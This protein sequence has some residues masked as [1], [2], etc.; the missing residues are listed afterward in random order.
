MK[1]GVPQIAI[2]DN[3]GVISYNALVTKQDKEEQPSSPYI[4]ADEGIPEEETEKRRDQRLSV[5]EIVV[6]GLFV[7]GVL[8]AV[9]TT[10]YGLKL[11][12][13]RKDLPPA[14]GTA[15][16][17]APE[18]AKTIETEWQGPT[19]MIRFRLFLTPAIAEIRYTLEGPSEIPIRF[20]AL[21]VASK[22]GY[23]EIL[24][25]DSP[26]E[27]LRPKDTAERQYTLSGSTTLSASLTFEYKTGETVSQAA[28]S[29]NP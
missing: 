5:G 18:A 12:P 17:P 20:L 25:D 23:R 27:T 7:V 28:V 8:V 14:G 19:G 11:A 24:K 3:P 15:S 10:W 22:G 2:H 4:R 1:Y 13:P 26:W 21:E 6:W 9:Y 29:F 16:F